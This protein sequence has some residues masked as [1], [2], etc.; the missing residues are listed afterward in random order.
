MV[1]Y[2]KREKYLS[3]SKNFCLSFTVIFH[4][5]PYTIMSKFHTVVRHYR[6]H[7]FPPFFGGFTH[8][9]DSSFFLVISNGDTNLLGIKIFFTIN[10]KTIRHRVLYVNFGWNKYIF[11]S[12][13]LLFETPC[14]RS[15]CMIYKMRNVS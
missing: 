1:S 7:W 6:Y 3:K 2:V 11:L 9:Y 5:R 4:N 14:R 15:K 8:W 12:V 13:F 10:C